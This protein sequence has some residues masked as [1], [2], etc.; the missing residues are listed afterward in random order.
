MIAALRDVEGA[1]AVYFQEQKRRLFF[2]RQVD[3]NQRALELNEDLYQAGLANE[4]QVL[5]VRRTLL[6][7]QLS[8]VDS[9][10]ALT[11]DLIATYKA[12]G[13]DWECSYTP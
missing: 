1:L 13:G 6:D 8:F 7:A 4:Q 3:A 9:E 11:T 2:G 10:Q 12:L 5:E